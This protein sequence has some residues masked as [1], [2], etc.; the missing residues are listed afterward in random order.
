MFNKKAKLFFSIGLMAVLCLAV[1]ALAGAATVAPVAPQTVSVNQQFDVDI[2]ISGNTTTIGAMDFRLDFDKAKLQ[3]ID[4]K[5]G[6][7]LHQSIVPAVSGADETTCINWANN[8]GVV[9]AGLQGSNNS[10]TGTVL[11]VTFKALSTG[12]T[13]LNIASSSLKPASQSTVVSAGTSSTTIII[14][15]ASASII[16]DFNEDE[17]VDFEDLM[18]FASAW[19]KTSSDTGWSQA[20]AGYTNSPYNR[21]D[22]APAQGNYPNMTIQ[23]DGEVNFEDLM[24]FTMAWNYAVSH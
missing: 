9:G 18:I 23:P 8:T 6:N 2:V 20:V 14:E 22:I 17:N 19:G 12:T 13:S 15:E 7:F 11:T 21:C 10:S 16:G 4:Y 3:V 1:P 5:I 24:I